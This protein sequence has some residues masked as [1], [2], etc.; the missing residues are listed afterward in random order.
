MSIVAKLSIR[1]PGYFDRR[2]PHDK[3]IYCFSPCKHSSNSVEAFYFHK[4]KTSKVYKKNL[5]ERFLASCDIYLNL[6]SN[7]PRWAGK[8]HTHLTSKLLNLSQWRCLCSQIKYKH[9]TISFV[10]LFFQRRQ[11]P[12]KFWC[13]YSVTVY[14]LFISVTIVRYLMK[15]SICSLI[16]SFTLRSHEKRCL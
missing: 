1:K 8:P 3:R 16:I 6:L 5:I 2:L 7:V 11:P 12:H 15:M 10:F 4:Q 14:V 13:I 9:N